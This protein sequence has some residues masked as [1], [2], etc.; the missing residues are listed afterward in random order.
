MSSHLFFVV[1]KPGQDH[2][3]RA[4][5]TVDAAYTVLPSDLD[6]QAYPLVTITTSSWFPFF[7]SEHF[8]T[9]GDA[10]VQPN[11]SLTT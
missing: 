7:V 9:E 2:V 11:L 5:D 6:T 3:R 10:T 8:H 1:L 4:L